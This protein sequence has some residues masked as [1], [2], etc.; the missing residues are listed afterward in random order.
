MCKLPDGKAVLFVTL[1][2]HLE[3]EKGPLSPKGKLFQ[4]HGL[5]TMA[6]VEEIRRYRL[7]PSA[8][9]RSF[10]RP[11]NGKCLALHASGRNKHGT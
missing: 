7:M 8:P 10:E 9:W 3:E 1:S 2:F 5:L 4:V 6:Q 11:T